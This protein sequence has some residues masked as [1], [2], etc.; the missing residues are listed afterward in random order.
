MDEVCLKSMLFVYDCKCERYQQKSNSV[1]TRIG[2]EAAKG[3]T[4]GGIGCSQRLRMHLCVIERYR[5]EY[6]STGHRSHGASADE[7]MEAVDSVDARCSNRSAYLPRH[8]PLINMSSRL[9]LDRTTRRRVELHH[10]H[11]N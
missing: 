9:R 2:D 10:P 11:P 1:E 3:S 4:K 8:F 7:C 5:M 6:I